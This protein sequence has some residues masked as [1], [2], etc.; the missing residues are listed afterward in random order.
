MALSTPGLVVRL[1]PQRLRSLAG[2]L[3][4][5]QRSGR[6]VFLIECLLNQNARDRGAASSP[7]AQRELIDLLLDAGVG[8][9][10][11]PCPEISCLGFAR[12]RPPGQTLR[13]ALEAE[14]PA[15]CCEH[16]ASIA[17]RQIQTYIEQGYEV[18]AILGGNG[19]SPGC[20]VHA[21]SREGTRLTDRS[22]LFMRALSDE[23]ARQDLYIPF[24]GIRDADPGLLRRDIQWLRERL[25]SGRTPKRQ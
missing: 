5:D 4:T 13:Q 9:V 2:T 6:V 20:A 11:M 23:L 7:G 14:Q 12:R 3:D 22:G 10:Q 19:Q 16:L 25:D 15:A 24:R 17:A 8:L 21:S 18:V 1:L